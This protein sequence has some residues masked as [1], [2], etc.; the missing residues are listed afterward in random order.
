MIRCDMLNLSLKR[1]RQEIMHQSPC[2]EAILTAHST[3][4]DSIAERGMINCAATQ[5][6]SLIIGK[7][8]VVTRSEQGTAEK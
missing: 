7:V 5:L 4:A 1:M 6:N 3:T 8:P 2:I